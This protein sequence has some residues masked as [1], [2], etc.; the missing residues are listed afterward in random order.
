MKKIIKKTAIFLIIFSLVF[1][2]TL[3][4][5]IEVNA[6]PAAVVA[7]EAGKQV[8]VTF[9]SY[10]VACGFY[11]AI[12]N[13][14]YEGGF[15]DFCEK[16]FFG[17]PPELQAEWNTLAEQPVTVYP[18]SG[19]GVGQ[20][21]I[22]K[23]LADRTRNSLI[24]TY[25]LPVNPTAGDITKFDVYLS[26]V[27]YDYSYTPHPYL[28]NKREQL[29]SQ[30]P[31]YLMIGDALFM[32][33]NIP[34]FT[35][36]KYTSNSIT[37][38]KIQTSSGDGWLFVVFSNGYIFHDMQ[39]DSYGMLSV[40]QGIGSMNFPII[41]NNQYLSSNISMAY[42]GSVALDYDSWGK[43]TSD[44]VKPI[45]IPIVNKP[46]GWDGT[47]PTQ[48]ISADTVFNGLTQLEKDFQDGKTYVDD[49]GNV[50][51]NVPDLVKNPSDTMIGEVNP[52][53]DIPILGNILGFLKSILNYLVSIWQSLVSGFQSLIS[54]IQSILTSIVSFVTSF[55]DLSATWNLDGILDGLVPQI[56][57]KTPLAN[58]QQSYYAFKNMSTGTGSPPVITI[59]LNKL[60]GTASNVGKF[61]NGFKNEEIKVI[62]FA[63]LDN[64][65]MKFFNMTIIQLIRALLSLSMVSVTA[66]YIYRKIIPDD[67]IK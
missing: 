28:I 47:V 19:M 13:G 8:I 16:A 44:N 3:S 64:P 1:T 39:W 24:S 61:N 57:A 30:Y 34:V 66:F 37:D 49:K 15:I 41:Y 43:D 9:G 36:L 55:F 20:A 58:F 59:N 63:M 5:P 35:V 48:P 33:K 52:P 23:S 38:W 21:Q 31:Y 14:K 11:D 42:D 65:D 18:I 12:T 6:N 60:V 50:I 54:G 4:K 67:V 45:N 56:I 22:P 29:I 26:D 25:S 2:F 7:F 51:D 27:P 32:S 62:D 53:S 17:L 46:L 10:L 40:H